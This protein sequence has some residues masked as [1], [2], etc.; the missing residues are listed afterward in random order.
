VRGRWYPIIKADRRESIERD[1]A[2]S[3]SE[4]YSL[5]PAGIRVHGDVAI[6]HYFFTMV[7]R[8]AEG[9]EETV[10]GHWSDILMKQGNKWTM[11]GDAGD[12]VTD[13]D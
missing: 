12:V 13:D 7:S 5:K 1:F 6:V 4:C 10:F 2:A 11:I 8:D 3:K 9:D